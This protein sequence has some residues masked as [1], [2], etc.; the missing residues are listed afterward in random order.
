MSE[1]RT[2]ID[3]GERIALLR[4]QI[5]GPLAAR[6]LHHGERSA[7]L[8]A[9]SQQ[10]FRLP[11]HPRTR[12]F[13]VATLERWLGRYRS[14]GLAALRPRRRRDAGRAR[15]LSP[16]ERELLVDIREAYPGA[17][18]Q[19]ILDSLVD[20]GVFS[21]GRISAQTIRRFY[22][23]AG[24][25]R[26][27]RKEIDAAFEADRQRLRWEAAEIFDVFHADVCHALKIPAANGRGTIPAL[28]HLVLDDR[29]RYIPR[30]EVRATEREQDM[31]EIVTALLREHGVAPAMLYT[32]GGAT[33]IGDRLKAVCGRLRIQLVHPKPGDPQARGKG[34]RI[35]RTMREQCTDLITGARSL[36]DV[37]VRLLAWRDRYHRT[38]HASLFGRTPEQVWRTGLGRDAYARRPRVDAD[39]LA[40]AFRFREGR[41]V[42]KDSTLTMGG[43]TY[44]T[45][46]AW[47][48]G[49]QVTIERSELAPEK[50]W[51]VFEDK[52][53]A[54]HPVDPVRNRSRRRR[55]PGKTPV[56]PTPPHV[57]RLNPAEVTLRSMLGT[58]TEE[59]D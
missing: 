48:A 9:L 43:V 59:E 21:A 40:E 27:S 14:G 15:R 46:V 53:Y 25:P 50:A 42:R 10:R 38:P 2:S 28:V 8:R 54:L 5:I 6:H 36:H 18:A 4:M 23:A 16:G 39:A 47:L 32:D 55:K 17:S 1:E 37:Y 52:R 20:A 45:E 29:S 56:L 19:Y 34:E 24:I 41:R 58:D 30:L 44:E 35:F 33:Y 57:A 31:L 51:I 13:S 22:R 49:K 3:P 26:R 7:E 12:T 11:G